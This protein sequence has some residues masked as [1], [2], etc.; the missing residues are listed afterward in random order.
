MSVVEA[1]LTLAWLALF[2]MAS[3]VA[4]LVVRFAALRREV[5]A[6]LALRAKVDDERGITLPSEVRRDLR[7]RLGAAREV[8]VV[9][10]VDAHC[11]MCEQAL[12]DLSRLVEPLRQVQVTVLVEAQT[13]AQR[14]HNIA[15]DLEV[16]VSPDMWASVPGI[17][18]T[19]VVLTETRATGIPLGTR[20]DLLREL[21][22]HLDL[23]PD[24]ER[25][26]SS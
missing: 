18:P 6:A 3:S 22:P 17:R 15:P 1:A 10:V 20:D 21:A 5:E 26:I 7:E 25:E 9:L 19:L 24:A 11:G 8:S 16:R 14:V 13:D 4:G 2:V 12:I 23:M